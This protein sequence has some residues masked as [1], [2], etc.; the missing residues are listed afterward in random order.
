MSLSKKILW[1]LMAAFAIAIGFYP[2]IY[3][4][5]DRNFG[6]LSSKSNELL[7][8]VFWNIG[9]YTHIIFGGIALL[10]GWVQFGSKFRNQNLKLHKVIGIV[11]MMSVLCSSIAGIGIGFFATGGIVASS[12]FISLG[13]IWFFTTL[14]AYLKIKRKQIKL[15]QK[16]MI[17]S[18]AA[19]FA[20]VT[21]RIW[22]PL[23]I[24]AFGNFITAYTI[25][26]WLCWIPNLIVAHL[27]IR[28]IEL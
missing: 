20:A 17:Y 7:S 15:H 26:A 27:I 4:L 19:C 3:F 28:R 25:V 11:Y 8:N 23:L 6:L 9:F 16:F 5:A 22:L 21:L 12:G 24:M 14:M 18:Y 2:A 13:L 1:I 10:I